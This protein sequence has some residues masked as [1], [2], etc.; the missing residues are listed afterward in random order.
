MRAMYVLYNMTVLFGKFSF[1]PFNEIILSRNVCRKLPRVIFSPY[2]LRDLKTLEHAVGLNVIKCHS[3]LRAQSLNANAYKQ[4][5]INY[6]RAI[7]SLNDPFVSNVS[8]S[9]QSAGIA[10]VTL[11]YLL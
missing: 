6:A 4:Y 10:L 8:R 2:D 5:E 1:S 9:R 3:V 11:A 7:A